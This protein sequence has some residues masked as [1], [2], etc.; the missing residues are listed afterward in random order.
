M[1]NNENIQADIAVIGSGGAGLAAAVA[2]AEKGASV[3]V[4]EKNKALG[5][6]SVR[7]EGFFAADSP[8][9]QRFGI[10][11]PKD[12]LFRMAMDYAHWR[13]N[14][15]IMRAYIDKSGDTVRWLEAKGCLIDRVTPFY[16]NQV[17]RVWHQPRQG[18]AEVISVLTKTCEKLGVRSLPETPAKKILTDNSGKIIGVNAINDKKEI[19]IN[20]KSVIIATGGF[21]GNKELLKKYCPDY[22]EDINCAAP[23]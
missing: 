23:V 15:R 20:V 10:D 8:A 3:V 17:Y 4:L 13:I 18:G 19:R 5:G 12:V 11:A 1:P 7:A 14:P 22:S 16:R 9:Q 2:A 6:R 21:G